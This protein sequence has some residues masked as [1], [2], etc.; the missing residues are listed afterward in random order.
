MNTIYGLMDA[1]SQATAADKTEIYAGLSLHLTFNPGPRTVTTRAKI[2]QICT[3]EL[4][5]RGECTEIPM[6]AGWYFRS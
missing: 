2:G 1:L 6:C 5:P 3:E 4:C